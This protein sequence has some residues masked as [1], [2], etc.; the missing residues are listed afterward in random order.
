[1]TDKDKNALAELIAEHHYKVDK[2][3]GRYIYLQSKWNELSLD[4]KCVMKNGVIEDYDK[5]DVHFSPLYTLMQ[6]LYTGLL[7][8]ADSENN[9][10]TDD[11]EPK[12]SVQDYINANQ[13]VNELEK[14]NEKNKPTSTVEV[15]TDAEKYLNRKMKKRKNDADHARYLFHRDYGNK[16]KPRE[17]EEVINLIE[18]MKSDIQH[19]GVCM[20]KEEGRE[21]VLSGYR[22]YLKDLEEELKD[23]EE[24]QTEV[25]ITQAD[26]DACPKPDVSIT[27]LYIEPAIKEKVRQNDIKGLQKIF[28]KLTYRIEEL[29]EKMEFKMEGKDLFPL[30]KAID[31]LKECWEHKDD[32]TLDAD[33]SG[34]IVKASFIKGLLNR[35]KELEA[36]M[37]NIYDLTGNAN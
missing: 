9:A 20:K 10:Q 35:I 16:T 22:S 24:E 17:K 6:E 13:I 7:K 23:L 25:K 37:N 18:I 28:N 14:L 26:M 3:T 5:L 33:K 11:P 32:I 21:E 31:F 19:Y 36:K 8:L 2:L 29:E 12:I 27:D 1:M 4:Q 30:N 15:V 34:F